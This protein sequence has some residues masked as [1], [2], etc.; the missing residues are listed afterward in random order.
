MKKSM[1]STY[2]KNLLQTSEAMIMKLLP[3]ETLCVTLCVNC[4]SNA[5]SPDK[6]QEKVFPLKC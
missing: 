5:F 3:I 1:I 2:L 6:F 4:T